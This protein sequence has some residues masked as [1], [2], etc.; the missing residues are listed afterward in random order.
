M[1]NV[2]AS[3]SIMELSWIRIKLSFLRSF[4]S[5]SGYCAGDTTLA[6]ATT[7]QKETNIK[8]HEGI[9]SKHDNTYSPILMPKTLT[10]EPTVKALTL[11][12]GIFCGR[13]CFF[14]LLPCK[15]KHIALIN[16]HLLGEGTHLFF[17]RSR[18]FTQ[19]LGE[20]STTLFRRVSLL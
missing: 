17:T 18:C 10:K 1:H 12:Q 2:V 16:G 13:F 15:E 8:N 3:S 6:L 20:R 4:A 19:L 11:G 9:A 14:L 7:L 5:R